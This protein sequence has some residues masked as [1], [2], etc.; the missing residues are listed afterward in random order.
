M[1]WET[2]GAAEVGVDNLRGFV[3]A[4][5]VFY[6]VPGEVSEVSGVV[7][8]MAMLGWFGCGDGR[9]MMVNRIVKVEGVEVEVMAS[10]R[11]QG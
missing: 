11:P 7:S 8:P 1:S 2:G 10:G 4:E 3:T 6:E 9:Q 5:R